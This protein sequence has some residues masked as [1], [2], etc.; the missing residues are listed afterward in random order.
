MVVALHSS[1]MA[2]SSSHHPQ[3]DGQTEIVNATIEQMLR[4]YVSKDRSAW[5]N[6]LSVLAFAYNSA[7]HSSTQDMPNGLLFNYNPKVS[8]GELQPRQESP[9]ENFQLSD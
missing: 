7:K 1:K 6:W 8:T 5:A 2:L 9:K 3:T 4:A